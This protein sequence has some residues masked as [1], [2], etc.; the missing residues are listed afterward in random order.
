[1]QNYYIAGDLNSVEYYV[2]AKAGPLVS[3]NIT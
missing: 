3:D 1:M 2:E